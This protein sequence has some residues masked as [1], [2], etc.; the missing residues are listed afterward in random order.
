MNR[1]LRNIVIGGAIAASYCGGTQQ[2]YMA[3]EIDI[4]KWDAAW[5]EAA[6]S[7]RYTNAN[8]KRMTMKEL[9][10]VWNNI[11]VSPERSRGFGQHTIE[12]PRRTI[13]TKLDS[14]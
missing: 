2:T 6:P 13:V 7:A 11:T 5:N 9:E 14:A 8:G 1:T 10:A 12:R 4:Q 3:E